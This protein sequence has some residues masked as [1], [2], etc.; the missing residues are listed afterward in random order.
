MPY[1]IG[2]AN[3]FKY[4]LSKIAQK[5]QKMIST[6]SCRYAFFRGGLRS[7]MEGR[8]GR[9]F[10]QHFEYFIIY[11]FIRSGFAAGFLEK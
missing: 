2:I 1:I 4:F 10:E 3:I 7:K 5:R 6:E 11:S 8:L 9:Q